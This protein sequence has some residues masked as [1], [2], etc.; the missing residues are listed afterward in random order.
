MRHLRVALAFVLVASTSGCYRWRP[1]LSSV[2]RA[3]REHPGRV[4]V[5]SDVGTLELHGPGVVGDSLIG[6]T[7]NGRPGTR[8]AIALAD[9][10]VVY[11]R[12][13]DRGATFGAAVLAGAGAAVVYTIVKARAVDT[14]TFCVPNP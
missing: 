2:D 5:A 13:L 12:S 14:C 11:V 9:V 4:R 10:Q 1:E 8:R 7:R 6:Y 3:V